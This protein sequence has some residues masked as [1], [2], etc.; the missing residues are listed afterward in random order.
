M[1]ADRQRVHEIDVQ[2]VEEER[3]GAESVAARGPRARA[4][5]PGAASAAN[6]I[7]ASPAR[8]SATADIC[9]T[10]R[11]AIALRTT[12]SR[13][14]HGSGI[15]VEIESAQQDEQRDHRAAQQRAACDR[16]SAPAR[17][18]ARPGRSRARSRRSMAGPDRTTKP[19]GVSPTKSRPPSC[20]NVHAS[21]NAP[22]WSGVSGSS[23]LCPA[24]IAMPDDE[25]RHA[26]QPHQ[27][28]QRDHRPADRPDHLQEQR[29]RASRT[30]SRS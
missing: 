4:G 14:V 7:P 24:T 6:P 1:A 27:A 12:S 20:R 13:A 15:A 9:A 30:T 8:T 10:F 3:H 23:R 18:T 25:H 17:G 16:A 5:A 28:G 11:N 22:N 2:H 19:I 29:I 21:A 26:R